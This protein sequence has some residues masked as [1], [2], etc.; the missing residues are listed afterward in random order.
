MREEIEDYKISFENST[1]LTSFYL[2]GFEKNCMCFYVRVCMC[3]YAISQN[4]LLLN[5]IKCLR[6]TKRYLSL[7]LLNLSKNMEFLSLDLSQNLGKPSVQ[8]ISFRMQVNS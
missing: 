8:F 1:F 4:I 2:I 7:F 6:N 3:V 5:T